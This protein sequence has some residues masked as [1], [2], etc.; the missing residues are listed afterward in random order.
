M[1]ISSELRYP[2]KWYSK[3]IVT[4]FALAF[5]WFLTIAIISLFLVNRILSPPRSHTNLDSTDFPG[6]P[7]NFAFTLP[8]GTE[9]SGW[10]FPGFRGAPTVILCHGYG[11]SRGELLTLAASLQDRQ[12]N[13]FLFDFLAHGEG[14]GYS[15]MGYKEAGELRAA[16]DALSKR[17]DV[18]R[19]R[20][21]LWGDNLGAYA[22][23]SVAEN[24]PVIRAVILE[25]VYN[26]PTDFFKLQVEHSGL[27]R[28]PYLEKM[29]MYAFDW[30]HRGDRSVR[31]LSA[32]L[33]SLAGVQKL[34]LEA[35]E[36]PVL[37]RSTHELFRLA[38]EPKQD[39]VLLQ[40]NYAGMPDDSKRIYENRVI[41]FL[42]VNFPA[43]SH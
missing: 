43:V 8:D 41:S 16:V 39:A 26:Q 12:Y 34:F 20:F 23:L 9:R 15:T 37:A 7:E 31:P 17:D 10:F 14:T 18:D 5:F 13:V 36:D 35:P 21:A 30:E 42:L 24:D 1:E 27:E 22:A 11:S 3:L 19:T 40:G 2:T 32:G 6:R 33:A 25:S 28:L 38:P 4:A 29:T